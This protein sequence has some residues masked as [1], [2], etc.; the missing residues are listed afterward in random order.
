MDRDIFENNSGKS[1]TAPDITSSITSRQRKKLIRKIFNGDEEDFEKF[2]SL[3]SNI[4][5]FKDANILLDFYYYKN[6]VDP[7]SKE[8]I[9]FRNI[10]FYA[11]SPN[12]RNRR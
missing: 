1:L 8:A 11:Y 6:D 10:V 9:D 7:F 2:L 3:L 5:T 4:H 12:K